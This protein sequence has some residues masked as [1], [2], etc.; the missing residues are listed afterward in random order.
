MVYVAKK[1][2]AWLPEH[3]LQISLKRDILSKEDKMAVGAFGRA[4][5]YGSAGLF[6]LRVLKCDVIIL[7]TYPFQPLNLIM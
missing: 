5:N 7:Q 6:E 4:R 3:G 2:M 1:L